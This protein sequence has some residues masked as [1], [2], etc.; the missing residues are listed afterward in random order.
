ME[1][2]PIPTGNHRH[3]DP[4]KKV[5]PTHEFTM[6]IVAPPGSGKTNLIC[7]LLHYYKNYFH[8]IVVV[9]PSV[10]NDEK[11]NWVKKQNLIA[12][13]T[14]LRK[15]LIELHNEEEPYEVVKQPSSKSG[16]PILPDYEPKIPEENF[17]Y[18]FDES[19]LRDIWQ[20]Q[21]DMIEFL[22]S[23]DKTKHLANRILI[24][25]DDMVGSSLFSNARDNFF[26]KMNANRRHISLSMLMVSQGYKE[27][28]KLV[29]TCYSCLILF[30]IMSDKEIE[31]ILEEFPMGMKAEQWLECYKHCVDGEYNFLYYNMMRPKNERI[32]KNFDHV[33]YLEDE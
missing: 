11:W 20:Q 13:N 25:F 15:F 6:G 1:I 16:I 23:H 24:V 32:M 8:N 17:M 30:E 28:P 14:K 10:Y 2:F 18:E 33:V 3:P 26:K 29:R 21:Q 31:C 4:P 9:S 19:V 5:L 7:N 27:I 12:D 22:E